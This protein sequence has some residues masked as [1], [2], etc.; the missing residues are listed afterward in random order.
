MKKEISIYYKVSTQY[1]YVTR[2]VLTQE[3]NY[4]KLT[5]YWKKGKK[6]ERYESGLKLTK[7]EANKYLL[8]CRKENRF[9]HFEYQFVM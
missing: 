5:S 3:G 1:E 2:R 4:Y 7:L 8:Q 6:I 9:D